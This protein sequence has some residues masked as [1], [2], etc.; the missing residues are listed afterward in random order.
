M[1]AAK[2][3]VETSRPLLM[4]N[5]NTRRV[6]GNDAIPSSDNGAASLPK[7]VRLA[8]GC[9]VLSW[10]DNPNSLEA[11]A[12]ESDAHPERQVLQLVDEAVV[13]VMDARDEWVDVL[14]PTLGR[15][16]AR[17]QDVEPLSS[18]TTTNRQWNFEDHGVRALKIALGD[19]PW[20]RPYR[21]LPDLIALVGAPLE[22]LTIVT[23]T[24]YP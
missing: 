24:R 8:A 10:M 11:Y 9:N 2:E 23:P 18:A 17:L 13:D 21:G 5:R 4:L 20:E 6:L 22:S 7:S 14:V 12:T 15:C 3:L 19:I 16:C 1:K